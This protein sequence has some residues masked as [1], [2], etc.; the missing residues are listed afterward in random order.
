[1]GKRIRTAF[2]LEGITLPLANI[3]PLKQLKPTLKTTTKYRQI[4]ASIREVG[5]IEPLVVFPQSANSNMYLLVDG[6]VRLEALKHL[7]RTEANCLISTDDEAY[8]YNKRVSRIATIQEHTML[9]RAIKNG[10]SEEKIARTLNVDVKSINRRRDLLNG[11]CTEAA[12]LL[13]NRQVAS[14]L[15][16]VLRKMKPVRQIEVA[17]LMLL[18]NNCS[19]P[20]AQALLAA[21]PPAMLLNPDNRTVSDALSPEQVSRMEREME[22]LQRDLKQ[23]EDSHGNAVLNLVLARGYLAK[24][25]ENTKV[26]RYLTQNHSDIF[27]ELRKLV[28]RVSLDA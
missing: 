13:K 21:T 2:K 19:V 10:I 17:E 27:G 12:D 3:L 9:V 8:T 7:G 18:A 5:V 4:L 20:Y 22:V 15:F 11:I 14:R 26:V 28:D 6:H 24:L 16:C 1:M 23:V 25:F